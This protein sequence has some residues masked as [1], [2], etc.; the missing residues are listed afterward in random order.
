MNKEIL[1][2]IV[3]SASRPILL[4]RTAIQFKDRLKYDGKLRFIL[5]EDCLIKEKSDD[6]IKWAKDSGIFDI[7]ERSDP[8]RTHGVA[9]YWL[10]NQ[11]RSKYVLR[12]EED[13]DLVRDFD[14]TKATDLMDKYND[15]NQIIFNKRCTFREKHG[16]KKVEI[17]RDGCKL[18]ANM[19]WSFIPAL[20]RMSFTFNRWTQP[21][22]AGVKIAW[23]VNPMMKK[24]GKN[25]PMPDAIWM[26]NNVGVY[27]MGGFGEHPFVKHTGIVT[28]KPYG[29]N[30]FNE[31]EHG[32][33]S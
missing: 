15:I 3:N 9:L 26:M 20:W 4:K 30:I 7:I 24:K 32:K 2:V 14:L 33:K 22:L 16:W 19:H 13:W 12:F 27:F 29:T 8:S 25:D 18:T 5:H 23:Y 21:P 11:V 28:T 1:D 10:L 31:E 17:E 6:L